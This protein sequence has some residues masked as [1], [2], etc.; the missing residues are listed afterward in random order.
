MIH[1]AGIAVS[2]QSEQAELE[3]NTGFLDG[4]AIG[5]SALCA[6]H[7]LALPIAL[8]MLPVIATIPLGDESFHKALLFLVIPASA[9]G[10]TLGCRR[11][12]QWLVMFWGVS[13]L[14]V[15]TFA[16]LFGHDLF[17]EALEKV[18]T[19]FG[20]KRFGAETGRKTRKA[21]IPSTPDRRH[22]PRGLHN[23]M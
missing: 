13:G 4:A 20:A 17:G 1:Y 23:I 7:C 3:K 19:L 22:R 6:I 9:I 12:R 5:L 14:L 8:T 16:A 11:H 10:L 21:T 15:M 18:A 2:S